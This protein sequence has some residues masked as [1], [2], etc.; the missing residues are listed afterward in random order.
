MKNKVLKVFLSIFFVVSAGLILVGELVMG[1]ETELPKLYFEGNMSGMK[2][3]KDLRSIAVTYVDGERSFEG[4]AEIKLQGTSSLAYRKKNY[5]IKLFQDEAH[6]EKMKVDMGWG[7][8]NKY[9]LKANWVD[10]THARNVVT[11]RLAAQAQQK[12]GVLTDTP[13]SGTV[14]GFPVEIYRNGRFLG[15]YTFNIPK[16]EW[17]FAMDGDNADHIVL[18]GEGWDSPNWFRQEPTFETWAVEVGEESGETLEKAK[19]LFDFVMTSSDEEFRAD[20]EKH[21]DLDAALNYFV[22]SEYAYLMDNRGKNMLLATYDGE[23][24]YPSLYDLDVSWGTDYD[25]RDILPY[26]VRSMSMKSSLLFERMEQL[27]APELAQRY[28][29]LRE[30]ILNREHVLGE[31][32]SFAADIPRIVLWKE[33]LRWGF[34]LPGYGIEQIE[35]YLN[36]M[37]PAWDQRYEALRQN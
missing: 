31:F 33:M 15:L 11:A 9:C 35:T 23:R 16:D 14:D 17:Q 36:D 34:Y 18:G 10:K 2:D 29:E 21:I 19:K 24:W 22:I 27:F 25:G 8:Q 1:A 13:C 28:F 4:Y 32:R 5:T 6:E 12:Y 37:E 20:F 30:D 3:K 26:R 7:E